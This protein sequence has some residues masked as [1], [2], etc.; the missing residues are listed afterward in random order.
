MML[1]K[2]R[3][4]SLLWEN[5]VVGYALTCALVVDSLAAPPCKAEFDPP[6]AG[7]ASYL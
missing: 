1:E 5:V 7:R 4:F 2:I 6:V 3:H